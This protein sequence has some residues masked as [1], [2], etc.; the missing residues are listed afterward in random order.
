MKVQATLI[1]QKRYPDMDL[2]EVRA[3]HEYDALRDVG[4]MLFCS[5]NNPDDGYALAVEALQL[6][7]K[8]L[9]V[10]VVGATES[11]Q[12][13]GALYASPDGSFME[14]HQQNI[15][16]ARESAAASITIAKK[17]RFEQRQAPGQQLPQRQELATTTTR[18]WGP[19]G[20]AMGGTFRQQCFGC[21]AYGH[22]KK[23]CP[24]GRN[25][26]TSNA[27]VGGSTAAGPPL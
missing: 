8:R 10:V 17:T 20:S 22:F 1:A 16:R 2:K 24:K 5:L 26:A 18:R 6:L 27:T 9:S 15:K 23:D 25:G 4:R 3:Q 11:W 19:S 21:G 13:A 12:V 7:E 14:D